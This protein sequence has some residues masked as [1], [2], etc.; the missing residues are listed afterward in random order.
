MFQKLSKL[1]DQRS[2]RLK[3]LLIQKCLCI[4]ILDISPDTRSLTPFSPFPATH[5]LPNL[6]GVALQLLFYPY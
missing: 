6:L 4:Y 3:S 1:K 2:L 5:Y